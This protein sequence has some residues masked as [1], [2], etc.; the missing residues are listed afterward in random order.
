MTPVCNTGPALQVAFMPSIFE[1][2][3][4]FASNMVDWDVSRVELA[5]VRPRPLAQRVARSDGHMHACML[6]WPC[7]PCSASPAQSTVTTTAK[8]FAPDNPTCFVLEF[9]I[10]GN[11]PAPSCA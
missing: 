8:D 2:C 5:E 7:Q 1:G 11:V 4:L 10:A 9:T 3:T 6:C